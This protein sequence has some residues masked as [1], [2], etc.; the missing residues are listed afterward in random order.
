M[1]HPIVDIGVNLMHRSFHE[2]REQVVQ[3]AAESQVSPL[4]I[5]G[6]SLRSSGE[7]ARYAARYPGKLYATAGVHPHD[8]KSCNEETIA[9]LRELAALPQVAA[10]G[11]CGLDYNRD[12]SPRD[13]QRHWFAEQIR[14]ALELDMPL[15]LHEREASADFIAILKEHAVS[16]AVVHCFTGTRSELKAYLDM[17]LYIG[18]T[19]WICDERRGKHLQELVR[20]IPLN[21]LMLETDAPFLTPRD[22]KEKPA[23]GRNEPA[24]LPH[25][26]QTVARCIGKPAEE[27]AKAAT[28]TTAEFFGID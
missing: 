6:T 2:D 22:L 25:I 16:K 24:F 14:L 15:F 21:R 9:K 10:I 17:G 12:F 7:A 1:N 20:M 26:L 23:N 5:T 4:I 27:V 11:E 8:A 19:G 3:R 18:I 13:V 28:E